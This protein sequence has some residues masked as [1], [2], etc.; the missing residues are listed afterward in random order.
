MRLQNGLICYLPVDTKGVNS[1]AVEPT[2]YEKTHLTVVLVAKANSMNLKDIVFKGVVCEVNERAKL[3]CSD[4]YLR[5]QLDERYS[6][7]QTDFSLLGNFSIT[8]QLLVW[9]G[10]APGQEFQEFHTDGIPEFHSIKAE[11]NC[12]CCDT[13]GNLLSSMSWGAASF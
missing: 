6:Q 5:E 11:L 4:L 13:V 1:V 10:A 3:H 8:P 7:P 9:V 12:G 2:W